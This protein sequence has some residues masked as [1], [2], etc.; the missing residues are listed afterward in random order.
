M[1][2]TLEAFVYVATAVRVV[3]AT[4]VVVSVRAT[5]VVVNMRVVGATAVFVGVG[6]TALV[7]NMRVV[8]ATAVVV[9]AVCDRAH[10]AVQDVSFLYDRWCTTNKHRMFEF[11]SAAQQLHTEPMQAA[12]VEKENAGRL[13]KNMIRPWHSTLQEAPRRA[14]A[15]SASSVF[16]F[17]F[18]KATATKYTHAGLWQAFEKTRFGL[19]CA[20]GTS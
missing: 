5:A 3:G 14:T 15:S 17:Y 11:A 10:D 20:A 8:G 13:D 1:V 6:A 2:V 18:W 7:V 4:A 19:A 9:G 16:M 12:L